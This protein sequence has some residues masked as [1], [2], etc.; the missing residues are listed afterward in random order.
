M[1]T[2]TIL[3]NTKSQLSQSQSIK[4]IKLGPVVQKNRKITFTNKWK[5]NYTDIQKETDL[6]VDNHSCLLLQNEN[7]NIN[8]LVK[9]Q[10]QQKING[11]RWQ[12]IKKNIFLQDNFIDYDFVIELLQKSQG[13]CFY[14]QINVQVIYDHVREPKQWTIER[15][16]N[17][18]G[19][20][21]GNVEIS[22][23]NCNLRR[24]TMHYERYLK[25]KQLTI[26]KMD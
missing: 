13:K 23:L 15:I 7:G 24:R 6:N 25:T 10:I 8:K 9:N 19:H 5:E 18:I 12:D 14:C 11:Y 21:K 2:R 3:L 1:E 4:E 22:C 20:N 16:D 17:S 26:H